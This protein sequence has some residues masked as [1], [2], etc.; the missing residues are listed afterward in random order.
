MY[1]SKGTGATI[2]ESSKCVSWCSACD[3]PEH[4]NHDYVCNFGNRV[5]YPK[6]FVRIRVCVILG[7]Q[8]FSTHPDIAFLRSITIAVIEVVG[9]FDSVTNFIVYVHCSSLWHH[10]IRIDGR[11]KTTNRYPSNP[12]QTNIPFS[13]YGVWLKLLASTSNVEYSHGLCPRGF[14]SPSIHQLFA[15]VLH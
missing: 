12:T 11:G 13:G 6:T 15:V 2:W 1:G 4:I 8:S 3:W 5:G 14:E 10:P 9:P 7:L